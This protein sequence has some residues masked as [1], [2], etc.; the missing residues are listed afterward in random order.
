MQRDNRF[1]VRVL[2]TGCVEA[3]HLPNSGR[4]G[5]LLVPGRTVWLAP[6]DL[7]RNPQRR[8]AFDLALVEFAGRL[9]SV[10][11]RVPGQLVAKALRHGQLSGFEDYTTVEREVRLGESRI[12]FRLTPVLG[13]RPAG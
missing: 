3:A 13:N 7:R 10:D 11:A 6:A 2:V 8:T 5:E 12:D 9:V 1:R 4:L